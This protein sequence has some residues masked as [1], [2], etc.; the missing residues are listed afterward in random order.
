MVIKSQFIDHIV[1]TSL[2]I[3]EIPIAIVLCQNG[4]HIE[5]EFAK[6]FPNNAIISGAVYLPVTQTSPGFVT[7][8]YIERLEIGTYPADA[9]KAHKD[10]V[11][12][13]A[14]IF[15]AG[16]GTAHV[17]DDVQPRRWNKLITN[18]SWNP[19]CALSRS[20]DIHL[21]NSTPSSKKMIYGIMLEVVKI[22]QACGYTDIIAKHADAQMERVVVQIPDRGIY[23]SMVGDALNLRPM[24]VE[25]IVGNTVRIAM[26]KGVEV[27]LLELTYTLIKA[28]DESNRKRRDEKA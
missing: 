27:P 18:A 2:P 3:F 26:E 11:Q 14:D 4:I 7:H 16:K 5:D 8:G 17:F 22:A 23:P 25:A 13:F 20:K 28:L 12:T 6:A 21:L 9:V 19:L 1:T 24:E 15:T 10:S